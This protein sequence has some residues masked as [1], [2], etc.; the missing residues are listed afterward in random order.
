MSDGFC[1]GSVCVKCCP[2]SRQHLSSSS[3]QWGCMQEAT[4][5]ALKCFSV[6]LFGHREMTSAVHSAVECRQ[7]GK[8]AFYSQSDSPLGPSAPPHQKR[9]SSVLTCSWPPSSHRLLFCLLHSFLLISI[10]TPEPVSR[11]EGRNRF[12]RSE[13]CRSPGSA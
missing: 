8:M 6:A 4:E 9:H 2:Q 13:V 12:G 3:V 5:H 7:K 1:C 10:S 11:C